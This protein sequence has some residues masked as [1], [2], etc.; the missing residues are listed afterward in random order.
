M[1]H[2]DNGRALMEAVFRGEETG[3]LP[4]DGVDYLN[5]MFMP[6][7]PQA[8]EG[9]GGYDPFG[10]YMELTPEGFTPTKAV[11]DDVEDWEDVVFPDP[12]ALGMEED[13][14]KVLAGF[15]RDRMM[16]R[17]DIP[18]GHF[19][20]LWSVAGF[21]NALVGFY[22]APDGTRAMLSKLTD[23][24]IEKFRLIKKYYDVDILVSHDD[25][26]GNDS[27]L[28][29]PEMWREFIKPELKRLVDATHEMGM[30]YEQHSCGHIQEIIG[31]LIEL[32]VDALQPLMA[33]CNDIPWIKRTYGDKLVLC[34]CCDTRGIVDQGAS[35]EDVRRKA[36]ESFETGAPGG[37]FIPSQVVYGLGNEWKRA[38]IEEE[39]Q[40]YE[41]T[42]LRG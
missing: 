31:D 22:A 9:R 25:W 29:S 4:R 35:E 14:K 17:M 36:R 38:V 20:R 26:G 6:E 1:N 3:R 37:R 34:G 18:Y 21:E 11:I 24:F 32:G 30:Y 2:Y 23:Y 7:Y 42:Y 19:E 39:L 15:D 5:L 27:M 10:V 33:S 28:F 40:Q 8:L 12:A 13:A 41:E 16:L